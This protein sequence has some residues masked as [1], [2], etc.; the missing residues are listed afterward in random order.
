MKIAKRYLA[1]VLSFA[2]FLALPLAFTQE[3]AAASKGTKVMQPSTIVQNYVSYDGTPGT[4]LVA[5]AYNNKGLMSAKVH[6]SGSQETYAYNKNGYMTMSATLNKSGVPVWQT[7]Y[8]VKKGKT[9]SISEFDVD[10]ANVTLE[11]ILN[12]SYKKGKVSKRVYSDADGIYS[13]IETYKNG[14]IAKKVTS[15][16]FSAD[17]NYQE[18]ALYDKYG[19][20]TSSTS[21]DKGSFGTVTTTAIYKNTYKGDKLVKA[22]WTETQTDTSSTDVDTISGVSVYTYKKG[23]LVKS[24]KATSASWNPGVTNGTTKTYSYTKGGLIKSIASTSVTVTPTESK[25]SSSS[26]SA[27]QYKKV[28]VNN[29]C[30]KA[31][32]EAMEAYSYEKN[33]PGQEFSG[34]MFMK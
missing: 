20:I 9:T 27:F 18:V 1:L 22:V 15:V 6:Q 34:D 14:K 30:V 7:I 12:I 13:Y 16:A 28:A 8:N 23:K 29:K 17:N 26:I 2:L 33:L 5:F 19:N 25:V 31:V 21:I 11:N 24:E 3:A 4:S 32:K 10:G